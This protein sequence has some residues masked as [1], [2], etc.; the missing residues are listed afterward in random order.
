MT[1]AKSRPA[2]GRLFAATAIAMALLGV[3]GCDWKDAAGYLAEARQF[4]QKGDDKSAVI[5][6]KNALQ[7]DPNNGE[8]RYLLGT[9]YNEAGDGKS[10]EKELRKALE[11]RQDSAKAMPAL[12]RALLLQGEFQKVLDEIKPVDGGNADSSA[13]IL[14]LRGNA[15]LALG[16][17]DEAKAAFGQALGL[18]ADDAGALL[19]Q[20]QVALVEKDADRAA[21][22]VEQA[23]AKTPGN[24]EAWLFK[25]SLQRL[26]HDNDGAIAAFGQALKIQPRNVNALIDRASVQFDLGKLD[27]AK[28]DIDAARKIAP[29]SLIGA[30]MQAQLDFRQGK[31]AAALDTLQQVL[32]VAPEHMPSVLLAGAAEYAL[33]SLQQAETH[34]TQF[35]D[36]DPGDLYA[37]KLLVSTLLKGNQAQRAMEVLQPGLRQAPQDAQL[38]ALASEVYTQARQVAKGTQYLEQA[39]A[40]EP[41]NAVLRTRL[42]ESHLAMGEPERGIAELESAAQLDPAQTKADAVLVLTHIARREFDQALQAALKLEKKQP[43]KPITYNLLG[44]AYLGG[45]DLGNARKSFERA[46]SLQPDYL[47]AAVSLARMDFQAKDFERAR[48]RFKD[49]I[50]KDGKNVRAMIAL[51]Q[52]EYTTGS[53]GEFVVWLEKAIKADPAALAPRLMLGEHYLQSHEPRKALSVAA[54]AKA[55][56]PGQPDVLNLLGRAQFASGEKDGAVATYQGLVSAQPQSPLA[57]YQLA[58][59]QVA[60]ENYPAAEDSLKKALQLKPDYLEAEGAL[61]YLEMRSKHPK[62][63]ARIVQQ[64]QRQYPKLAG[65]W[66]LEGDI[67]M[68]EKQYA[69]AA[70]AYEKAYGL[71]KSGALAIRSYQSLILAGNPKGAEARIQQWLLENPADSG[72]RLYLA[73]VYLTARQNKAAMEQ[74]RQVLQRDPNS[75]VALNNLATLYQQEKDPRAL[76]HA[77]QAYKLKPDSGATMDT[78]GWILVEQGKSARGLEL[79][80]K[81]A[82]LNPENPEIRFHLAA[83]LAKSGDKAG[84]RRDLEALL[85]GRD[86]FPQREAAEALLKQL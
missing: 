33:G 79:L 48:K 47:P 69:Q 41:N 36:K 73:G 4:Q 27:A 85:A 5:Q 28:A 35:L 51:A 18:H 84:A 49:I 7:K 17:N 46:L 34:L 68:L 15:S 21:A 24:I 23:L 32:R 55:S 31:F 62:E 80:R 76:E 58:T 67:L 61:A 60:T 43:D 75:L 10:A 66:A 20:A 70:K 52:F 63:A 78:L 50:A 9:V 57:Y 25:G 40:L 72:V 77:E 86:K 19:G 3:A 74:Y 26:R 12:G 71:A 22:L 1:N 56:F 54:E 83:A 16:R 37:R 45:K 59:V 64:V 30:Y 13:Q 29:N 2:A 38:L 8:A 82:T 44:L 53:A 14:T 65:G 6:L 39:A 11:M 42:G 81:A